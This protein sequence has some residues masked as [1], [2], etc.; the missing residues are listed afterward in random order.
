VKPYRDGIFLFDL[1]RSS[2]LS[3]LFAKRFQTVQNILALGFSEKKG[4]QQKLQG[5]GDKQT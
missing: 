3:V 2:I 4:Y 5:N 1:N